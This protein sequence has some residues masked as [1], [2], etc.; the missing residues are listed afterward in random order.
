MVVGP[1]NK[2]IKFDAMLTVGVITQYR[3]DFI[4]FLE[5]NRSLKCYWL[6]NIDDLYQLEGIVLNFFVRLHEWQRCDVRL[7][8][9][10]KVQERIRFGYEEPRQIEFNVKAFSGGYI[11]QKGFSLDTGFSR[12][13]LADA[14]AMAGKAMR[15]TIVEDNKKKLDDE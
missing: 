8:D 3:G 2:N 7:L 10:V 9:S 1:K 13:D 6:N 4:E 15:N 12:D 5:N 11:P 14:L